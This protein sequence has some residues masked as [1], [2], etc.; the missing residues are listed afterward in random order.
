MPKRLKVHDEVPA[1]LPTLDDLAAAAEPAEGP[2]VELP[3][4]VTVQDLQ[5]DSSPP[6]AQ[7]AQNTASNRPLDENPLIAQARLAY[8]GAAS[9]V[10][11][12]EGIYE[13]VVEV[14]GVPHKLQK[15]G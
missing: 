12:G 10:I 3:P 5:S 6:V 1:D 8:P 9:Y 14:D 15:G 4:G 2:P 7:P 13:F 11:A